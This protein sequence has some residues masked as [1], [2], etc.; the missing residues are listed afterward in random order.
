M[1]LRPKQSDTSR[2]KQVL[3]L[4][5]ALETLETLGLSDHREYATGPNASRVGRQQ[6]E[7]TLIAMGLKLGNSLFPT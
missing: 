7:D 6:I 1:S 3:A 2:L 4:G 5:H